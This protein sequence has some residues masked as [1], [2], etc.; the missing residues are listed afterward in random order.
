ML[1]TGRVKG[2]SDWLFGRFGATVAIGLTIFVVFVATIIIC[3]TCSC[4]CLYKMCCRPRRKHALPRPVH[5]RPSL[6]EH[7][8]PRGGKLTRNLFWLSWRGGGA[9]LASPGLGS[10]KILTNRDSLILLETVVTNTTTTVVHT[11]YTQPASVAPTYPGPTYQGYHPMPPQPGV[12]AAPYP[13][14][15][16][17]PYLAQPTGPPAYHETLAGEYHCGSVTLPGPPT[18]ASAPR[19]PSC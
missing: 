19:V 7:A 6:C 1:V 18:R 8:D 16:P 13:T 14:Q 3:F 17:P 2:G 15:Y 12:P 11:P 4:C 5:L 10:Y 9:G